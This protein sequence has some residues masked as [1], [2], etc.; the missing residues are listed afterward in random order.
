MAS[1]PPRALKLTRQQIAAFAGDDFDTIRQIERLFSTTDETSTTT[2]GL[3]QLANLAALGPV[4]NAATAQQVDTIDFT[5]FPAYVAQEARAGWQPRDGTLGIG[6]GGN[7][8]Q[9]VGLNS[10]VRVVNNSGSGIAAGTVLAA[11][12]VDASG[13]PEATLFAADGTMD[14]NECVGL[15]A[16]DMAD[17]ATG[18]ACLL[19]N[20]LGLDTSAFLAGDVLY[21]SVTPGALTTTP[22]TL[23]L[24]IGT[25]GLVS[26][27][28]GEIVARVGVAGP[29]RLA[30]VAAPAGGATVDAEA[31]TAI[32]ALIARLQQ[33]GIIA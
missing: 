27:T 19:G 12:T 4:S 30:T 2:A 16:A 10:Y 29:V 20:V 3:E 5:R 32:N 1:Q 22:A 15:A 33:S 24:H 28:E 13:V 31:R 9:A 14:A 25:V 18:Y 17:G 7:V 23:A 21:A 8:L 26:T 11:L 6:M